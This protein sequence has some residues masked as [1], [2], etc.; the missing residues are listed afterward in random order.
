MLVEKE[1]PT[2]ATLVQ[3]AKLEIAELL[4]VKV[5][6]D[7]KITPVMSGTLVDIK[8]IDKPNA[9]NI[10]VHPHASTGVTKAGGEK[11]VKFFDAS[12]VK[13]IVDG[14]LKVIGID[15]SQRPKMVTAVSVDSANKEIVLSVA[16]P[17]APTKATLVEEGV[18]E[19]VQKACGVLNKKGEF[20]VDKSKLHPIKMIFKDSRG[21]HI[22]IDDVIDAK[23]AVGTPSRKKGE[24]DKDSVVKKSD[25]TIIT[26]T[27]EYGV[28]VKYGAAHAWETA[29]TLFGKQCRLEMEYLYL[30]YGQDFWPD[31][32]KDKS[33]ISSTDKEKI[34]ETLDTRKFKS[35]YYDE[36]NIAEN[37]K[38]MED[39]LNS[40]VFGTDIKKGS[41]FIIAIDQKVETVGNK[42]NLKT[43]D[44]T[45][46]PTAE[47]RIMLCEIE[48]L[49]KDKSDI[50]DEIL[51]KLYT[52][53]KAGRDSKTTKMYGQFIQ[54]MPSR[55]SA[56]A[57]SS[58][59]SRNAFKKIYSQ[60]VKLKENYNLIDLNV[61]VEK[62]IEKALSF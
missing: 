28:S 29:T 61:K 24:L 44:V 58:I 54:V 57:L 50:P 39:N 42:V 1:Y 22:A 48:T 15:K 21:K 8:G 59:T 33:T 27:G 40:A 10:T 30:N 43:S 34:L 6:A 26:K 41:G 47:K 49:I 23:M 20:V 16:T 35:I 7:T 17:I 38:N 60:D 3:K 62:L 18:V 45:G 5:D 12:V 19:A 9:I 37:K 53:P 55:G 11:R 51:P 32:Y 56:V 4:G 13:P 36:F 25:V 46:N 31:E 14:N 2:S 52:Y